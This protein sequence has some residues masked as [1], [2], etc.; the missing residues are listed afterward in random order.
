MVGRWS[1][2]ERLLSYVKNAPKVIRILELPVALNLFIG[3]F[4]SVQVILV[5]GAQVM[6]K[7]RSPIN[8]DDMN[9]HGAT[10]NKCRLFFNVLG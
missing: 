5:P 4:H 8:L 6:R 3:M 9:I 7:C 1:R 10:Q 2:P